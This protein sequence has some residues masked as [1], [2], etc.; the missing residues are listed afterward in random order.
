MSADNA[1]QREIEA[2]QSYVDTVYER[3]D[4]SAKVAQSLVVEGMARGHVGNEGGLVERDAMVYQASKRLSALNAAHD[5]LVFGRLN[6]LDGESRYIGRI[7]VRDADRE[8]LL[9]DWRA[10]AAAIFYQATAQEPA[11]VVRRRVLRCSNDQVIGIED[12]LLDS[13]HA[14]DDMVVIGEGALLASLTRARDSSMHSVVATIQK[15]QDEAIRAPA[16]GATTIGG[17]PGTGKTVVALHR[18]AYLLY[19]DRRRFESGGV[20]VV[21]PSSV[22]MSYIERVLP[23]L[24]ETSVTLRSLGEVVDGL[25]AARHDE[26]VAAAAKGSSRMV[27][28]LSRAAAAPAPGAPTSFRYF[29]KDDVL[30][31]DAQQLER[32]RR[33]L[34]SGARRNRAYAKAPSALVDA[35]WRQV[36]G[37]RALEKGEEGF[38]ETITTDDR[39]VDFV[40]EWWPPVE[41]IDV[42]RT[43]PDLIEPLSHGAFN[44]KEI[45]ALKQSWTLDEPSI[46]DVPL[47]DELRY[48]L[49]ELPESG[50]DDDDNPKQLMSFERREREERVDR[51][52]STQSI[53]DDGFA[54]VL[55]DEAQDLSPMQ[56]RMLGRRGRHASWTIVGDQAQSSWPYPQESAAARTSALEGKPEHAFRL[57][58]NY[59]NSAEIYELAAKVAAVAVPDPDLADA[60]RRTGESPQQHVVAESELVSTVRRSAEEI[61]GRVDGTVAIVTPRARLSPLT[62]QLSDFLAEHADRLRLLDGLDTKGLEFDGVVVVEPDGI[63][64]ESSA[65]WRTLY[66]VLTRATQLLTTVGTT[67]RWST[68]IA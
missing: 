28:F 29:Y 59:R 24:G 46:Q 16:R 67:D 21:G 35:L 42:W 68:R 57:S 43:L 13:D 32:I 6:M 30:R 49:G 1:E 23:S 18:A 63:T 58:T 20:L 40:E 33:Q 34:L 52:R 2:E 8:I 19:T 12:D 26:P 15:E 3:L 11:G 10:P 60:V 53:E 47:I 41:P 56:W 44:A 55:V 7:G 27:K 22:F 36:R 48:I 62:E 9:V 31:L 51:F 61:L 4:A 50:D 37:D 39:F 17:G 25:R 65:G 14:P 45:A 38:V 5:G 64:D 54:H 66:V